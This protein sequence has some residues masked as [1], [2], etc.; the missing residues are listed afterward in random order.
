[1]TTSSRVFSPRPC[2]QPL[3]FR[4]HA[5]FPDLKVVEKKSRIHGMGAFSK[6]GA[7]HNDILLDVVLPSEALGED[8][9]YDCYQHIMHGDGAGAMYIDAASRMR[10]T[11]GSCREDFALK[12]VRL[13]NHSKDPNVA[14]KTGG[15][16]RPGWYEAVGKEFTIWYRCSF[17]ATRKIRKG[18]ELTFEYAIPPTGAV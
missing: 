5:I 14:I 11:F 9:T 7:K 1:M 10:G 8:C 6:Y 3:D 2:R 17:F 13:L 4:D 12:F 15:A 16:A 18:E